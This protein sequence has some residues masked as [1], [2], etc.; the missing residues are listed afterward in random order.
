MEQNIS[1]FITA[2][3]PSEADLKVFVATGVGKEDFVVEGS[4]ET[5]ITKSISE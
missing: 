1:L 4:F 5:G 3:T 2:A